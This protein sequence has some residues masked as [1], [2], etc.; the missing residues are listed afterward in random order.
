MKQIKRLK[1]PCKLCG[2]MYQPKNKY[3]TLCKECSEK[4][5]EIAK[6]NGFQGGN[7]RK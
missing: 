6:Q 7:I 1:R 3:G 2:K 5:F 4:A